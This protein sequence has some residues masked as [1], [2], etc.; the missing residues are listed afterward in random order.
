MSIGGFKK[1]QHIPGNREG[2]IPVQGR[3]H[4]QER[5]KKTLICHQWLLSKQEIKANRNHPCRPWNLYLLD[6]DFKSVF[7]KYV[8]RTK[9]DYV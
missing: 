6:K 5:L 9:G 7:L 4:V 3:F 1:L 2:Y 8:Q